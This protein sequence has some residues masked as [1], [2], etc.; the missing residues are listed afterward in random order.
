MREYVGDIK[1]YV[2]KLEL[3]LRS[4]SVSVFFIAP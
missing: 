4:D 1:L 3:W 2:L